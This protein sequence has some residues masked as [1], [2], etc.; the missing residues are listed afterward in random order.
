MVHYV[1]DNAVRGEVL[2][3][4]A[5]KHSNHRSAGYLTLHARVAMCTE[6][7]MVI[8]ADCCLSP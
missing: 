2:D 8:V 6:S 4:I 7:I 5:L 1:A 3:G